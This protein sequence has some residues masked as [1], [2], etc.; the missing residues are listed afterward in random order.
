MNAAA[1]N[2]DL[3][4]VEIKTL[5]LKKLYIEYRVQPKDSKI[6]ICKR[7]HERHTVVLLGC[8]YVCFE[9]APALQR[10]LAMPTKHF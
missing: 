10:G 9:V 3:Q 7:G 1:R 8:L 5:F 2:S 6:Y 4:S